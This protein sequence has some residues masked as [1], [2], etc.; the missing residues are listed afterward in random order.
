MVTILSSEELAHIVDSGISFHAFGIIN[1]A[2]LM[3]QN[4]ITVSSLST[5]AAM[6]AKSSF[7]NNSFL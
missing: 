1:I 3:F 6:S 5:A 4:S 7:F 2:S